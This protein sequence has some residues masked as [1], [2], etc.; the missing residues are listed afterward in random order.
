M[1]NEEVYNKI[2]KE[3]NKYSPEFKNAKYSPEVVREIKDYS[4]K[5]KSN[6][7]LLEDLGK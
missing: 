7:Q 5:Y 3:V 2:V 1:K 6:K 4:N